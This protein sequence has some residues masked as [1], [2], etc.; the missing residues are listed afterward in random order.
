MK[1]LTDPIVAL[2]LLIAVCLFYIFLFAIMIVGA[3]VLF[4]VIVIAAIVEWVSDLFR[5]KE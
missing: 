2:L 3:A 1:N 4:P 5:Y